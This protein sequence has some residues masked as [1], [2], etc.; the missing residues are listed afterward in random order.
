M[1]IMIV[2]RVCSGSTIFILF[3]VVQLLAKRYSIPY[4]Q[5]CT[6]MFIIFFCNGSN[7]WIFQIL[8]EEKV[9]NMMTIGECALYVIP[10]DEDV[11]SFELDLAYKVSYI[12]L[13]VNK[14]YLCK[15]QK[16]QK[17]VIL[18]SR[19]A[20]LMVIQP[21][22]G[23]QQKPFTS[24]RF[25]LSVYLLELDQHWQLEVQCLKNALSSRSSQL[26]CRR[27]IF[28]VFFSF[29]VFFRVDTKCKGQRKIVSPCCRHSRSNASRRTC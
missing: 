16:F 26:Y 11:L 18:S 19:N 24:L 8:E 4:I 1:Y 3:L 9:H 2:Q 14:F 29:A 13:S 12:L 22:F 7:I 5:L 6:I 28:I 21:L 15:L 17:L 27:Y 25:T 20:W 23:T 10:C